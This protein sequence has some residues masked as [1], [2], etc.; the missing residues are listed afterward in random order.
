MNYEIL[1]EYGI[2]PEAG[3]ARCMNDSALY[4]SLLALFIEDDT[5]ERVSAAYERGDFEEL[6]RCAHELK[7][8]SGN[9]DIPPLYDAVG[10]LVEQLRH[11]GA[12]DNEV[13]PVFERI[14]GLYDRARE[15]ILLA[16]KQ[17]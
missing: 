2:D 16:M 12:N 7:G 1:S 4:E 6:F 3:L 8:V 9:A 11:G 10:D 17:A 14:A 15:G 5:F 13:R